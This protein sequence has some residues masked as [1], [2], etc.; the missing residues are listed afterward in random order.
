VLAW[1]L[2]RCAERVGAAESAIGRLPHPEDLDLRGIDLG[3]DALT[4]LLTVD[5]ALWRKEIADMRE[6]L[7]RYGQRLPGALLAELRTTEER[8]P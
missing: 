6:Y 8:L 1:M 4:A 3:P 5:P 2:E 7:S